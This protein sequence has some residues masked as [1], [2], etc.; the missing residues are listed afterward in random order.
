MK[1]P[2]R[3]RCPIP[4]QA[5]QRFSQ[6]ELAAGLAVRRRGRCGRLDSRNAGAEQGEVRLGGCLARHVELDLHLKFAPT[7]LLH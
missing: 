5:D 1:G 7:V 2:R 6:V 3:I 4:E